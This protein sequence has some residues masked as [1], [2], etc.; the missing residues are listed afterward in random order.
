MH[1]HARSEGRR[2]KW[3]RRI[4][5]VVVAAVVIVGDAEV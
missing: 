5:V 1:E 2:I 3:E 4:G